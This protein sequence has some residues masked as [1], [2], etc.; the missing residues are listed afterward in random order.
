MSATTVVRNARDLLDEA[1]LRGSFLVRDLDT[2]QEIGF[3]AETLYPSASLVKVPLAVA[4]LEGIGRGELD[5]ATPVDVAPGRI[6]TPGPTGLSRFRHPARISVDDLLYLSTAVSDGVAADALFDLVPPAAVAAELRRL[7]IEGIAV[8]HRVGDLAE[9]PAERLGPDDVH[10]AHS[11][12]IGAATPGQGH[13]VAQLDV[14]R[15]N[16]GSARAFVDLLHA[17]WRPS[18]IRESTAARVRALMA[19]NLHRQRLAPDFTSDASR[20]SSKTGTLLHLRHEV[21][22]VDHADGQSYA[23]AALTASRVPAVAQP[24]SEATMA[25]VARSLHDHLRTGTLP[26]WG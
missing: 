18:T 22:V 3:D 21:G 19:D 2:G 17:L 13:P 16:A 15:A 5:P 24:G 20:W 26:W 1:G 4:V 10:L 7:R 25:Q 6:T 12:A 8:R 11:L 14:T 9:T 23:V